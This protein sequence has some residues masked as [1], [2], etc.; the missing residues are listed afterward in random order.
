M[1]LTSADEWAQKTVENLPKYEG[2]KLIA[3]SWAEKTVPEGYSLTGNS[4]EGTVTTLTNKHELEKKD[5]TAT[6]VWIEPV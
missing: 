1:V 3:Y 4:A 5:V 6:K 2:G